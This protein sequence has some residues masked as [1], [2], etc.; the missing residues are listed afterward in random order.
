MSYNFLQ[1]SL[2]RSIPYNYV[3]AQGGE[4]MGNSEDGP[5]KEK[6]KTGYDIPPAFL[7][8]DISL[9]RPTP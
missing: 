7:P 4:I 9:P 1:K 3:P 8:T 2:I 5:E 6:R